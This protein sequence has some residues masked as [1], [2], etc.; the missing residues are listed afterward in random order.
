MIS[1]LLISAGLGLAQAS[2]QDEP[3]PSPVGGPAAARPSRGDEAPSI[4]GQVC[5]C[6]TWKLRKARSSALKKAA[7]ARF[8]DQTSRMTDLFSELADGPTAESLPDLVG[9]ARKL[10]GGLIESVAS[11]NKFAAELKAIEAEEKAHDDAYGEG[12]RHAPTILAPGAAP[13]IPDKPL[14]R[15]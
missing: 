15:K 2:V 8:V 4:P 5:D 9:R 7:D 14:K 13:S 12:V 3:P 6:A 11:R 10:R 1:I